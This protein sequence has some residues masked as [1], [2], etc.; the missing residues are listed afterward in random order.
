MQFHQLSG[1]SRLAYRQSEGTEPGVLFCSGF[2]STMEGNKATFLEA[3]CQRRKWQFTRFDYRGHGASSEAFSECH[4]GQWR[5]DALTILDHICKSPQI[6]IGSSMGGWI[7]TLLA[8]ARPDRVAGLMT[9]AAAPDFT[10][11]LIWGSLDQET[12]HRLTDGGVWRMPNHYDDG[13]PYAVTMKLIESG[14]EH[15]LLNHPVDVTCP[16]R[17]LHGTGDIDVPF[18]LSTRLLERLGSTDAR[19]TLVKDAD[20]RFSEPAQLSLMSATLIELRGILAQ[21]D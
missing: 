8:L 7:A 19:L 16:A 18:S 2:N 11:E 9:V 15:L 5:E 1:D 17:L 12:Q 6:V 14:R 21:T 20:H 4:F 10:E 3:E 13:Q